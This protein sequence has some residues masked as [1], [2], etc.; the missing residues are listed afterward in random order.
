MRQALCCALFCAALC[1]S[2]NLYAKTEMLKTERGSVVH[3]SQAIITVGVDAGARSTTVGARQVANALDQAIQAW[4]AVPAAQ[5]WF[6]PITDA[7]PDV[8][9]SFCSGH[10]DG[11]TIDLGRSKFTASLHDGNITSAT[12]ELNE[13]DHRFAAPDQDAKFGF[14]LQSVLTHELGHVL[15]LGHSDNRTAI[16]FPTG[17]GAT[18]RAPHLEDQSVLALIYFGRGA[19]QATRPPSRPGQG[20]TSVDAALRVVGSRPSAPKQESSEKAGPALPEG[21]VSLLSLKNAAG[22]DVLIY[23]CEPTLLPP[24]GIAN[25]ADGKRSPSVRHPKRS[26]R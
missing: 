18:V 4:N 24:M 2:G 15:G 11:E 23:T 3:W 16:M 13:C 21:S 26:L 17:G 25:G 1:G 7:R 10:W 12:V 22:R 8:V 19:A 5:P 9:I 20:E 14:D 6:K